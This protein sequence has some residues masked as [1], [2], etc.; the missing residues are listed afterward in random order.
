MFVSK[1]PKYVNL[2]EDI[3]SSLISLNSSSMSPINNKTSMYIT[4]MVYRPFC[5]TI[6]MSLEPSSRLTKYH[7]G[8]IFYFDEVGLCTSCVRGWTC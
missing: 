5:S 7:S 8:P 3:K 4:R 2:N 1:A 6:Y